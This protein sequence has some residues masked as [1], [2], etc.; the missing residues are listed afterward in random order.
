MSHEDVLP[1]RFLNLHNYFFFEH[2]ICFDLLSIFFSD[3]LPT[4]CTSRHTQALQQT[5]EPFRLAVPAERWNRRRGGAAQEGCWTVAHEP[6]VSGGQTLHNKVDFSLLPLKFDRTCIQSIS[7]LNH[8][9]K[10][11]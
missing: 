8:D 11:M 3:T 7:K 2:E 5:R 1:I 6:V 4:S 9:K 10:E